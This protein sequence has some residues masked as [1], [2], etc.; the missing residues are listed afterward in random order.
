METCH[1]QSTTVI[2]LEGFTRVHLVATH[3]SHKSHSQNSHVSRTTPIGISTPHSSHSQP[4]SSSSSFSSARQLLSS[5]R[6]R[7]SAS[8]PP[9]RRQHLRQGIEPVRSK[10]GDGTTTDQ[11]SP[12][13]IAGYDQD[14]GLKLPDG[15]GYSQF[16]ILVMFTPG[17][18]AIGS[19]GNYPSTVSPDSEVKSSQVQLVRGRMMVRVVRMNDTKYERD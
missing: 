10:L 2:H 8:R 16:M 6:C 7:S 12:T 15:G 5:W 18:S 9:K 3:A 4:S 13:L 14:T 19:G 17:G 11:H 1:K